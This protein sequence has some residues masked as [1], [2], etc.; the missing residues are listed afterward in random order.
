[1]EDTPLCQIQ[2]PR[3]RPWLRGCRDQPTCILWINGVLVPASSCSHHFQAAN[4]T[5]QTPFHS[6]VFWDPP[7]AYRSHAPRTSQSKP[8]PA[9]PPTQHSVPKSSIEQTASP[10]ALVRIG[11]SSAQRISKGDCSQQIPPV[12]S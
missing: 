5:A 2:T 11:A 8:K 9:V 3:D 7:Q 10:A 1:M 12:T 4:L 6:S